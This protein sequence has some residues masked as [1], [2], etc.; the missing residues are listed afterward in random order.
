MIK[1]LQI[2][3]WMKRHNYNMDQVQDALLDIVDNHKSDYFE[4]SDQ[5]IQRISELYYD[6]TKLYAALDLCG[7]TKENL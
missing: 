3:K 1:L 7:Y 6:D 5:D 4:L 2:L